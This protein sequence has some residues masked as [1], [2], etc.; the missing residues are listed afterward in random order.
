MI[1]ENNLL[2]AGQLPSTEQDLIQAILIP[3]SDITLDGG[4]QSIDEHNL[5]STSA[6]CSGKCESGVCIPD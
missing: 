3:P 4:F 6:K 5:N 2:E 1:D